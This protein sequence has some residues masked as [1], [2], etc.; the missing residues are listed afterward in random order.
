M[1]YRSIGRWRSTG[2]IANRAELKGTRERLPRQL[3]KVFLD[4]D[5]LIVDELFHFPAQRSGRRRRYFQLFARGRPFS[6]IGR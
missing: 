4:G 2:T 6:D 3:R 5:V 1:R